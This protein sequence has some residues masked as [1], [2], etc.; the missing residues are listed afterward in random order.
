MSNFVKK[1]T[2]IITIEGVCKNGHPLETSFDRVT[3]QCSNCNKVWLPI[4]HVCFDCDYDICEV[5]LNLLFAPS[6]KIKT[7]ETK[8]VKSSWFKKKIKTEK[9][10][11]NY[12]DLNPDEVFKKAND[13][14]SE[15]IA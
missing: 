7:T 9:Q 14:Y 6:N 12:D 13:L 5:C 10:E 11:K 2:K 8:E 1:E 15:L 3:S 4:S